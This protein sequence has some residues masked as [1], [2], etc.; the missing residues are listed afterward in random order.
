MDALDGGVKEP[1]DSSDELLEAEGSIDRG[2]PRR[3]APRSFTRKA[4]GA[5]LGLSGAG[6]LA[7]GLDRA[8]EWPAA[9]TVVLVAVYGT[10]IVGGV[11]LWKRRRWARWVAIVACA[12]QAP[13]IG[14]AG[15][16]WE[17][18]GAP[19]CRLVVLPPLEL[20]FATDP[21]FS[22]AWALPTAETRLGI[23]LLPAMVLGTLIEQVHRRKW[24]LER[25]RGGG[26]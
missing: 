5:Y 10:A 24:A 18:S 23:Q 4:M 15:F 7:A 22:F 13:S 20:S 26:S 9:A 25:V 6:S 2:P 16:A 3:V 11:G 14:V 19:W 17:V 21:V 1:D 8:G 12:L